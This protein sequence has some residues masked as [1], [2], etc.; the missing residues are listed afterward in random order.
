[1]MAVYS[2]LPSSDGKLNDVVVDLKFRSF[3]ASVSEVPSG[4]LN[5]PFLSAVMK[6][7]QTTSPPMTRGC[8]G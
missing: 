6:P 3:G 8:G 2:V 7:P 5:S 4:D 1:M